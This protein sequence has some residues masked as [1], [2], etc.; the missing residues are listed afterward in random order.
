MP[1]QPTDHTDLNAVL[2][3]LVAAN[4]ALLADNFVGAYLH[5][6]FA[7]GD[8]DEASDVDYMIVVQHEIVDDQVDQVADV[9]AMQSRVWALDSNWAK[10][11][12]GSYITQH[13][14]R[15]LEP[16]SA[17]LLYFDNG[18]RVA[19]R[20]HHDNTLV[21]RWQLRERGIT[22]A[23]PDIHGLIDPVPV[24]DL[25]REVRAI[26][27]SRADGW[28][29]NPEH[30]GNRFYQP[31]AVLTYC[32]ML[33]TLATGTVVSKVAA[34]AWA[35]GQLEPRW[36]GLIQRA[37]ADRPDPSMRARTPADPDDVAETLEFMR[38]V[39]AVSDT[40]GPGTV[41]TPINEA[42]SAPAGGPDRPAP[43]PA[44]GRPR[45]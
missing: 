18:S 33:H 39:I 30:I 34:A 32:R 40:F 45:G 36:T 41:A 28:F 16:D 13:A 10:H 7:V 37:V 25:R 35:Q 3:Q 22:L 19:E 43:L 12:E 24:D 15:R 31:F 4:Q 26:M 44:R 9:E 1:M 38:H 27:Y 29:A 8:P 17:P 23:G 5:G 14:L 6:S 11:L 20:S 21:V 42:G 2:A